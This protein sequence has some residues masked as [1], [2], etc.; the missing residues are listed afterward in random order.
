MIKEVNFNSFQQPKQEQEYNFI[1]IN[2]PVKLNILTRKK[3]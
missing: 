2:C 1:N 3:N